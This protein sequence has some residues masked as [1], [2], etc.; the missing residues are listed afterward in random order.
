M[1][2]GIATVRLPGGNVVNIQQ[3]LLQPRT[4]SDDAPPPAP[5][6]SDSTGDND[7]RQQRRPTWSPPSEPDRRGPAASAGRPHSAPPGP[8]PPGTAEEDSEGAIWAAGRLARLRKELQGLDDKPR[9][10]RRSGLRSLQRELHPDKQ[11]PE[12]RSH[13]QPLFM[14]VQR[15][16]EMDEAAAKAAACS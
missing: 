7:Q 16:W 11:P 4:S 12:L 1:P 9:A 5:Q 14:L 3:S 2:D 8:R 6:G 15:E 13:A 10:E